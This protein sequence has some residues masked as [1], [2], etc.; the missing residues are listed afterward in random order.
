MKNFLISAEFKCSNLMMETFTESQHNS[1]NQLP[2]CRK[3]EVYE[4]DKTVEDY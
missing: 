3:L 2:I 1:I 4:T